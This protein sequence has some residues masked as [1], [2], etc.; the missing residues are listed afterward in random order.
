ME[1]A[2]L[3]AAEAAAAA[4]AAAEAAAAAV[5]GHLHRDGELHGRPRGG[6][7]HGRPCGVGED[8]VV[9][10]APHE[11]CACLGLGTGY[12]KGV[13]VESPHHELRLSG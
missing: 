13:P 8:E 12:T 9:G 2:A 11:G 1:A 10:L 5:A 4:A 7:E 3:E 6:L